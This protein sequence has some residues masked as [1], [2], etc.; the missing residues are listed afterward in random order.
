MTSE[1]FTAIAT[2][3]GG[4]T[5]LAVVAAILIFVTKGAIATA[6]EQAA[7]LEIVRVTKA[8]DADLDAKRNAFTREQDGI[9]AELATAGSKEVERLRGELQKELARFNAHLTF[10]A[11][12]RRHAATK[13]VSVLMQ[14]G[15]QGEDLLRIVLNARAGN[16]EDH[17]AMHGKL[18]E[19]ASV[20]R[21]NSFL[22][23]QAT[24]SLM[25]QYSADLMKAWTDLNVN[26]DSEAISRALKLTDGFLE[27]LRVELGISHARQ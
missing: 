22:V 13:A 16:S 19:Y 27:L 2:I 21:S 10:D 17:A 1:P 8:L 4:S 20:V 9:K 15:N 24:A 11:E 7:K 18:Y 6:V 26:N 23:T 3:V 5:A 14:I 12:V 25:L